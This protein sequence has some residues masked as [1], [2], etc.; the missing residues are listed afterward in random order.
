VSYPRG[1]LLQ[2]D[3]RMKLDAHELTGSGVTEGGNGVG[4]V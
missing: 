2:R 3:A 4:E 1:R